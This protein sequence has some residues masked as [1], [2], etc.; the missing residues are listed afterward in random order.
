MPNLTYVMSK[1]IAKPSALY[2]A[3]SPFISKE[4]LKAPRRKRKL[5]SV[6]RVQGDEMMI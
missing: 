6:A 1:G 2:I 4:I 3:E 5:K